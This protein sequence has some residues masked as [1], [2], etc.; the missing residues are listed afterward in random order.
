MKTAFDRTD[1]GQRPLQM[2][3]ELRIAG[4]GENELGND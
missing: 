1:L 2:P 3:P 4:F